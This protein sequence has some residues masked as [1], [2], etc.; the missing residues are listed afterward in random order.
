MGGRLS[1]MDLDPWMLSREEDAPIRALY[2]H[3]A[4]NLI[5][6]SKD[7]EALTLI[8]EKLTEDIVNMAK[9][10]TFDF[11]SDIDDQVDLTDASADVNLPNIVVSNLPST[12]V[13]MDARLILKVRS[14]EN[15]SASGANGINGAQSIRIKKSTGAWGT[16]DIAAINLADNM[17]LIPASTKEAGDILIG[18]ND[19][20]SEVDG[21]ATYNVRFEDADVDYNNLRLHDVQVG[22]RVI[23]YV[24]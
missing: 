1:I 24:K 15:T 8:I 2:E 10:Y 22:L 23:G 17:W 16:D 9:I 20:K 19:L 11:W 3:I 18:D 6:A 14:I 4:E 7:I 5:E 13:F 12:L 21:N